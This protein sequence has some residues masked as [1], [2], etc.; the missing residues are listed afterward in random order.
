LSEANSIATEG[1]L[2]LVQ[3]VL[4]DY[5]VPVLEE[6]L[7]RGHRVMVIDHY[8]RGLGKITATKTFRGERRRFRNWLPPFLERRGFFFNAFLPFFTASQRADVF[9]LEGESNFLENLILVP[10]LILMRKPYVWYTLGKPTQKEMTWRRRLTH[11]LLVF[12]LNRSKRVAC[13][14]SSG[15]DYVIH[16][17]ARADRV[18]VAQ[19]ALCP[20]AVLSHLQENER[21]AAAL[22]VEHGWCDRLRLVYVGA[23]TAAK[24]PQLLIEAAAAVQ[25]RTGRSP[26]L[27]LV[28]DGPENHV[29]RELARRLGVDAHFWGQRPLAETGRYILAGH[30]VVLPGLGG[31]AINHAMMHG[32]MVICGKADGTETDLV[33]D[34]KTGRLLPRMDCQMLADC[35]AE[36]DRDRTVAADWGKAAREHVTKIASIAALFESLTP[37]LERQAAGN[38]LHY[39]LRVME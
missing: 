27:L 11:P 30:A 13:Y 8:E 1:T 26:V 22:I 17:G 2:V 21:A 7:R 36:L 35:L 39:D 32:R 5:R 34:R 38:R 28:G 24:R 10:L 4:T 16:R 25:Q 14:S 15:R 6:G 29:C 23:L 19:N 37:G 18:V 3:R 12:F 9:I 20:R 33:L 31:L